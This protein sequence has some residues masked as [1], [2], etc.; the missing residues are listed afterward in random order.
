MSSWKASLY[1]VALSAVPASAGDLITVDPVRG[2]DF[3]FIQDAIDAAQ[4]GDTIF[5]RRGD[6]NA[7]LM[8]GFVV[9]GKSLSIIGPE[10]RP[11][12]VHPSTV[13]GIAGDQRV[14]LAHLEFRAVPPLQ[15]DGLTLEQNRG[16]VR[17]EGCVAW[18][19]YFGPPA[20]AGC[21]VLSCA[22]VTLTGCW[23]E[24]GYETP[25]SGPGMFVESSVVVIYD[26]RIRGGAGQDSGRGGDGLVLESG[27]LFTSGSEL[28]GGMGG[29]S[30]Y[31]TQSGDGGDG[32]VVAPQATAW[33]RDTVALGG[34]GGGDYYGTGNPG[35]DGVPI[36]GF[37]QMFAVP[38]ASPTV[39]VHA[40][41]DVGTVQVE[42]QGPAGKEAALLVGR[43]P[44]R[45]PRGAEAGFQQVAGPFQ[46][47]ELG[48][49]PATGT[50]RHTLDIDPVSGAEVEQVV[51]QA[52]TYSGG[53]GAPGPT[54]YGAVTTLSVI[55]RDVLSAGCGLRIYV[56]ADAAPG[57]DGTSW[58]TA[59]TSL[60][61]ALEMAPYCPGY[62]S[63]IW[64]AEGTYKPGPPGGHEELSFRLDSGVELYGG[65]AGHETS[66]AQRK[67]WENRT[68]LSADLDGNDLA[69]AV[70]TD[71]T[72]YVVQAGTLWASV[73]DLRLDGLT[74]YGSLTA[75]VEVFGD[76]AMVSC[77]VRANRAGVLA[78]GGPIHVVNSLF[79]ENRGSGLEVS[80]ELIVENCRFLDNDSH[81][82]RAFGEATI[83]GILAWRNGVGV[84]FSGTLENS[85]IWKNGQDH[86]DAQVLVGSIHDTIRYCCIMAYDGNFGPG[87]TSADPQFLHPIGPDGRFGTDDDGFVLLETSPCV[88]SGR[89]ASLGRDLLDIDHDGDTT[90]LLPIDFDGRRRL[91]DNPNT[92]DTGPG[93]GPI[94]DMGPSESDYRLP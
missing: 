85:I 48:P 51:V 1:L 7:Q 33:L 26:T 22:D 13:R 17:V 62:P 36:V 71:N 75:G 61:D 87:N 84:R 46:R 55:D 27:A 4:E 56:D 47:I 66:L 76:L 34:P 6:P 24:G 5:V 80:G 88:D 70:Q 12:R 23:L 29:S 82:V 3:R 59:L 25:Q 67:P 65:F 93:Q 89:N 28:T 72:E 8:P 30:Y 74:I 49:L 10:E 63:Q 41:D 79:V 9:D 86:P 60:R 53:P 2:G 31:S 21:R 38:A 37:A 73:T 39:Q 77:D 92:E 11:V 94:V 18:G 54:I 45:I 15:V 83:R 91:A 20:G 35:Q 57:G 68:I 81:G 42:V 64:L 40:A 90:E 69:F 43:A 44:V 50:L 14:L 32:L 19:S 16:V 52:V 78:D 58:A